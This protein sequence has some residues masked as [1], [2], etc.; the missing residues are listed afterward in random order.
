MTVIP[1]MPLSLQ[2]L[3]PLDRR[4]LETMLESYF[5]TEHAAHSHQKV[6]VGDSELLAGRNGDLTI[7]PENIA[8]KLC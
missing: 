7:H 6:S 3:S 2:R 1:E 8:F 5:A 4:A